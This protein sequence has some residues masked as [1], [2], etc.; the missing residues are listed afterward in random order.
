MV[1]KVKK[2]YRKVLAEIARHEFLY[3]VAVGA[4]VV[5]V[6]VVVL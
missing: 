5:G 4:I 6:A 1:D 3:G 2:V